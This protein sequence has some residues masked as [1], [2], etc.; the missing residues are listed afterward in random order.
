[1]EENTT[2]SKSNFI[3]KAV[4]AVIVLVIIIGAYKFDHRFDAEKS[5]LNSASSSLDFGT[6][7]VSSSTAKNNSGTVNNAPSGNSPKTDTSNSGGTFIRVESTT[8]V[9]KADTSNWNKYSN[10]IYKFSLLYPKDAQ[11]RKFIDG[12]NEEYGVAFT[13]DRPLSLFTEKYFELTTDTTKGNACD[14]LISSGTT[15]KSTSIGPST[16][17]R[18]SYADGSSQVVEYTSRIGTTCYRGYLRLNAATSFSN[19][20]AKIVSAMQE[21]EDIMST[22][23]Y[24]K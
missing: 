1:M 5:A 15:A 17:I 18:R 12:K 10:S 11:V 3:G 21:L 24:L 6:S 16:F 22:F 9:T 8:P 7:T 23:V 4:I 19:T 2:H 14:E 13:L 20:D